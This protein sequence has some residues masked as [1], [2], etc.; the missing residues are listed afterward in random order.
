M[1][2]KIVYF[3]PEWT[4]GSYN[5]E[6]KTAIV[7][8]LIEGVSHYFDDMSAVVIGHMLASKRS[9][10]IN[11][12]D[13]A[14]KVD[15]PVEIIVDF[16]KQLSQVGL[17]T[18]RL[19][20]K[21]EIYRYR[22]IVAQNNKEH[23]NHDKIMPNGVESIELGL[24]GAE[25]DYA[26][27]LSGWTNVVFELTYRC[28]EKCI[29]CYNVG[30]THYQSDIDK[31]GDRCELTLE[32]Y[33]RVIDELK[34]QG[35]F[36]ICL[37]GGDPFSKSIA[38]NIIEYCY[39]KEIAVELYTN[40]LAISNQTEKLINLYPRIVG[41]TLY[42]SIPETHDKVTRTKG[43]FEKTIST[44]EQL[45]NFGIPLQ[46]KCCV[47]NVN[48]SSYKGVY[49]LA[50]DFAALPQIEVNIKNTVDGNK[51]A[52]QHL[53]LTE[54]EYEELFKDPYI[55]PYIQSNSLDRIT[56]RDFSQNACIGG[57]KSCTLTPEGDIIPCPA[58]HLIFGNV[59]NSSI[60][61]IRNS[62]K[63]KEW[64]KVTLKEYEKCG[65]HKYCAFCSICPGDNYSDT[66]SPLKASD[67]KCFMAKQRYTYAEKIY[68]KGNSDAHNYQINK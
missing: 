42:S 43:S 68:K 1:N 20:N 3:R 61:E 58:F 28:S 24:S 50:E 54:K 37:T 29:H 19:Y 36:K 30:S 62:K 53:R 32:E 41:L 16:A 39:E 31:R 21:E 15:L 56:T 38:W 7:Y 9:T 4:S 6:K 44:L 18:N 27:S 2:P 33:K 26:K 25:E 49:K 11:L 47:F 67:N 51:Y 14:I 40:G 10:P 17:L 57:V 13:I 23:Y 65:R 66:G 64:E 5:N 52:S 12:N 22:K 46:L 60:L 59:R 55:Y 48:F 63:M 45:S 8:N 34:E 35:M